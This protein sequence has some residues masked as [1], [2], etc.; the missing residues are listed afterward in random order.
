[1]S[2]VER[3]KR[4]MS[5]VKPYRTRFLAA[6]ACSGLVALLSGAY[7][8]LA[9][10]VLDD[11]F[12]QKNEQM[13][14]VLPLALLGI[15]TLNYAEA[16]AAQDDLPHAESLAAGALGFFVLAKSEVHRAQ[17]L[18]VLGDI[19]VRRGE[20]SRARAC[21]MQ[22]LEVAVPLGSRFDTDKLRERLARLGPTDVAADRAVADER[23]PEVRPHDEHP[24][25]EATQS[26]PV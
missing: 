4:L 5:Y 26:P 6:F 22:G 1:M 16:L 8:W 10:P 13:L 11:I 9:K 14:L 12:I 3:F 19:Y 15:A 24:D 25:D 23:R 20:A 17:C 2:G 21:Y 18:R 7:A